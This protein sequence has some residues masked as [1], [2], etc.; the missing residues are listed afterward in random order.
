M[1]EEQPERVQIGMK[2]WK[3]LNEASIRFM[4]SNVAENLMRENHLANMLYYGHIPLTK[5]QR[6]KYKL[7]DI[8]QRCKDIWI[9]VTGGN[10]HEN[11]GY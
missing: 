5:W 3:A 7:Q 6:F 9:I 11:C 2:E 10:I 8:K 1:C 4:A